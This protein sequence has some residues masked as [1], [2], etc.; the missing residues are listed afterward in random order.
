MLLSVSRI[1]EYVTLKASH[2]LK[3]LGLVNAK[4][5]KKEIVQMS[6]QSSA[7]YSSHV[8]ERVKAPEWQTR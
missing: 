1:R 6:A 2:G 8:A 3:P 4:L 7:S 5:R